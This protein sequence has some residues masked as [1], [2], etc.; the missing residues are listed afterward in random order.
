[1]Y[2]EWPGREADVGLLVA[3]LILLVWL[4]VLNGCAAK[5]PSVIKPISRPKP[6]CF[7]VATF[8][9]DCGHRPIVA[10]RGFNT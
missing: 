4:V 2:P 6:V 1:M 10:R 7:G 5:E 3:F 8:G 9:S